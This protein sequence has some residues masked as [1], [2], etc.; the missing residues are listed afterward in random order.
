MDRQEKI[1]YAFPI[2]VILTVIGLIVLL[3]L[4]AKF[5]NPE[6][7]GLGRVT[8]ADVI[9]IGIGLIVYEALLWRVLLLFGE[10]DLSFGT[11]WRMIPFVL[12]LLF[13]VMAVGA[14][15]TILLSVA[16]GGLYFIVL[17]ILDFLF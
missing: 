8:G 3:G 9:L 2:V 5:Y 16:I 11:I 13:L 6:N 14:G 12:Y 1:N 4:S 15:V 17:K 7:G 10:E